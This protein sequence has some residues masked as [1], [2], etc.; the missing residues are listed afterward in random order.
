MITRRK[1]RQVPRLNTT[2]TADI[3][4]MLLVFF[5]VTTSM[6]V[7]RGLRRMLP[8]L[9]DKTEQQEMEVAKDRLLEIVI[10]PDGAVV[11]NGQHAAKGMIRRLVRDF[12]CRVGKKHIISIDAAP[13]S[14]YDTY[15]GIQSEIVAAYA[16][17]RSGIARK[18]YKM[19]YAQLDETERDRVRELCPVRISERYDMAQKKG[20]DTP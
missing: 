19:P 18:L 15:F 12:V 17:V 16:E 14:T 6:D 9:D 8:T 2:S 7:D 3:S 20:E 10:S 4:F 11:V 1:P 13:E 5:L